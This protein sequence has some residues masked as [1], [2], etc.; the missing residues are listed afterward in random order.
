MRKILSTHPLHPR[1]TSM[2]AG[3]G[4]LVVAS[5]LDAKTLAAEAKDADIVIVRAPLPPELFAGA[6]LL[7]AAIRHGAGLDMI[8]VEAATAA[9]VLVANVPAVNARSVAEHVVFTALALLRRFRIMDRDLRAKG[10]LAG[11]EHANSTS[12]LAGKT[13]GIVGLGAVGQAV[14]HIAAHGFDLK[15]VATTRSLRPAPE[16]VGFLSI[17]ALVEQ[18]EII[19]LCCPLTEETRGLISRERIARMKPNALLI[20]VS[21]GPVVDDEALIEA[22]RKGRIGGA[23]LDVFAT[24]PL[25]PSHPYF[26]FDNVIITPHMA[27]ITEESMMRMGVGAANEA[28]LVLA[29]KLPVNLRNPEVIERYRRRFPAD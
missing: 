20:N 12:E 14:G 11:R 29:D 19:V 16:R 15:V 26:S 24:Q 21:R 2:L 28:L 18:S 6:S 3:A 8:P 7:R 13:I 23:A 22:L 4:R 17:D 25:P 1:A 27:G 10:W 5:A 9:G